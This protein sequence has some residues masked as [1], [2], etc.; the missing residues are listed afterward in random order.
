[1][2]ILSKRIK[3]NQSFLIFLDKQTSGT[4]GPGRCTCL[5]RWHI[6]ERVSRPFDYATW[7]PHTGIRVRTSIGRP[8]TRGVRPEMVTGQSVFGQRRQRQSTVCLESTFTESRSIVLRTH[9]RRQS[10]CLVT[11]SSWPVGQWWRYGR[12]LHS[13]LEYV[14]RPTDAMRWHRLAGVQFGVVETF[15]GA[16]FDAWLFAKSDTCVEVSVI[17]AG[18]QVDGSLVSG[19][20]FG[21]ES[22]RRGNCDGS[23]WRDATILECFQ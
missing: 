10:D 22:G 17:D 23:R 7:H 14:N 3:E 1:M 5:E 9:G 11:A 8:S 19:T 18:G 20:V 2:C 13:L 4:F 15:V 16:R 6:I 21:I 12:S